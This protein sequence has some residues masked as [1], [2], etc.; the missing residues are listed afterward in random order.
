VSE[1][2]LDA[3]VDEIKE[4]LPD[5]GVTA[6]S[7]YTG[8]GL[9]GLMA[10]LEKGRTYCLIGSSGVGKSSLINTLIGNE[11]L[12]TGEISVGTQRGQHVTTA[13]TLF[14]LP[15]GA[16]IIDNPGMRELGVLDAAAG[17]GQIFDEIVKL[18]K[19]CR[20]SD[21]T[22]TNESG[23]A[24]RAAIESGSLDESQYESYMKLKKENEFSDMTELERRGKDRAFGKFVKKA[25]EQIEKYK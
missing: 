10:Q 23:C 2:E 21:C 8:D 14:M 13:R 17:I 24:V 22:H 15:S 4:R 25:K 7:T 3:M 20:F 1:S 9:E 6:I 5:T 19:S 12:A 18:A 16:M 11:V